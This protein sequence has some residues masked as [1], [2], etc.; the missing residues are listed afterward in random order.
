[1]DRKLAPDRLCIYGVV[2]WMVVLLLGPVDPVVQLD[3]EAVAFVLVSFAALFGG[4]GVA[5]GGSSTA[6]AWRGGFRAVPPSWFTMTVAMATVG[7]SFRIIDRFILRQA[8]VSLDIAENRSEMIAF[9]STPSPLGI[10]GALLF[11]C[12]LALLA[13]LWSLPPEQRTV[14]KAAIA[15]VFLAYPALESLLQAGRSGILQII[16]CWVFYSLIFGKNRFL[17]SRPIILI[18]PAIGVLVFFEWIFLLRAE[19]ADVTMMEVVQGSG[20]ASFLPP[21]DWAV[22]VIA[23]DQGVFGTLVSTWLHVTQYFGHAF[24]VFLVNVRNFSG[25][26]TLGLLNFGIFAKV[27]FNLIGQEMPEYVSQVGG[28]LAGV[29]GTFFTSI[30]YDFGWFFGPPFMFALGVIFEKVYQLT[31]V[32]PWQWAP[33]YTLF[34][35]ACVLMMFDNALLGGVALLAVVSLT[36]YALIAEISRRIA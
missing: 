21:S 1:M 11:P 6:S 10:I 13:I 23:S 8:P 32:R 28:G 30:Y 29:S 20:Y 7:L 33:L 18:P 36:F 16:I 9:T 34:G 4:I 31:F 2:A 17:M 26:H 35:T 14:R 27:Y 12:G 22:S 24:F 5:R 25:V 3:L 19:A 15:Y